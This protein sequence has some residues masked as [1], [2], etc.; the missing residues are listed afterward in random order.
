MGSMASKV[1]E[2]AMHGMNCSTPKAERAWCGVVYQTFITTAE[3]T[4]AARKPHG[5]TEK[6]HEKTRRA[7]WKR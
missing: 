2:S 5:E 6:A 7:F 4:K 1:I 3:K